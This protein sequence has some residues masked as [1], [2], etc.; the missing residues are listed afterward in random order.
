MQKL[1]VIT[2]KQLEKREQQLTLLTGKPYVNAA[3][4]DVM[5][6]WRKFGWTPPSEKKERA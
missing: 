4:T 1:K 2:G 5:N 6:T 3:K